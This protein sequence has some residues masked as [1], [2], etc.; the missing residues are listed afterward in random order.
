MHVHNEIFLNRGNLG[1][2][3]NAFPWV[4][5][6]RTPKEREIFSI[7]PNLEKSDSFSSFLFVLLGGRAQGMWGRE[8]GGGGDVAEGAGRCDG[9]Y[10]TIF[11]NVSKYSVVQYVTRTRFSSCAAPIFSSPVPTYYHLQKNPPIKTLDSAFQRGNLPESIL[12]AMILHRNRAA[13]KHLTLTGLIHQ[14][15]YQQGEAEGRGGESEG[16]H[17]VVAIHIMD[18][19]PALSFI[20]MDSLSPVGAESQRAG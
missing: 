6:S 13:H 20:S 4:K 3:W 11:H 12:P 14:S 5:Y 19:W 10:W 1:W 9:K 18:H 16:H 2:T 17:H 8:E 7:I 15:R